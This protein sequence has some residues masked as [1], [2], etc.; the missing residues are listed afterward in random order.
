M[1]FKIHG[2]EDR[3]DL[4]TSRTIHVIS[5][6]GVFGARCAGDNYLLEGQL[7]Q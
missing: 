4:Y 5:V 3:V 6:L 7:K 1:Y 2:N